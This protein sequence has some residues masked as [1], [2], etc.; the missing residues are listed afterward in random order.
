MKPSLDG[1][2][3][4]DD[5][6]VYWLENEILLC[7]ICK[8]ITRTVPMLEKSFRLIEEITNGRKVCLLTDTSVAGS[9]S[10]EA[11][12]F[13]LNA[14]GN[15]F[16]AMAMISSA[17]FSSLLVNTFMTFSSQPIP[18]K[19]F[20]NEEEAREWLKNYLATSSA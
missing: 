1:K 5:I 19:I 18:M 14:S 16:N 2:I 7:S 11:R 8:P 12:E 15:H 4:E 3:Y 9:G 13:S 17:S 10:P 6:A 20:S